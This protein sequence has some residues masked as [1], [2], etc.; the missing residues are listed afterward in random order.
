M[1]SDL[2]MGEIISVTANNAQMLLIDASAGSGTYYRRERYGRGEVGEFILIEG[3]TVLVFGRM[4]EVKNEDIYGTIKSL[5]R[6]QFLGSVNMETLKVL[7]GVECYPRLGDRVYA[8]PHNFVSMIPVLMDIESENSVMLD[9]GAMNTSRENIVRVKPEKIF[10]RHLAI[11]GSTGGGKSWTTTRII[12][13]CIKFHSKLILFDATGEYQSFKKHNNSNHIAYTI[14]SSSGDSG[15][16]SKSCRF[17]PTSFQESDFFAL[18]TPSGKVQGPKLREAIRSLRLAKLC[19]DK[20]PEGWIKKI[21]QC[22]LEYNE[23]IRKFSAEINDPSAEFDV[24]M[25]EKQIEQECVYP[26]NFKN[27]NQWGK[28][29]GSFTYCL[30]LVTRI[31]GILSSPIFRCVFGETNKPILTDIIRRFLESEG[32]RLL[33]IDLSEVSFEYNAREVIANAIGRYLLNLFRERKSENKPL[34]IFLDEAHNFLGKHIG[35]EDT[36]ARLDAFE[37]IAKEGRKFNLNICIST[38]RP[39]DV[40]E[41]VLSQVGTMIVHRLT[42]DRD[43][44]IVERASGEMDKPLS[45]FLPSLKIGEAVMI[46]NHFPI[47]LTIQISAPEN[48]P[49]SSGPNYQKFWVKKK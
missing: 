48:P 10:G 18:F 28:E 3:Q 26:T 23:A 35:N 49:N 33:I 5:G 43:R 36:F 20:Y 25:L 16:N 39:R 13:Q 31:N 7:A 41:S 4:L 22:K 9:I 30:T 12:E 1:F 38:Q 32:K 40:T 47:P 2:L 14:L 46:G 34:I 24:N 21:E 42:N 17:P 44:E 27:Q 6:I 45:A 37:L 8:A 11:L 19:S 29:D 15:D